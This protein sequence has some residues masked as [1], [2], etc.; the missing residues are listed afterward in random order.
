MIWS[1]LKLIELSEII[2]LNVFSFNFL[3]MTNLLICSLNKWQID[4]SMILPDDITYVERFSIL[5]LLISRSCEYISISISIS[6]SFLSESNLFT[7]TH[8]GW[9]IDFNT[10]TKCV[11]S[12]TFVCLDIIF[13]V[14]FNSKRTYV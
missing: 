1:N 4:L 3:R 11:Y 9:L 13:Y 12:N 2:W 7:P 8:L 10:K 6:I 14:F 5:H